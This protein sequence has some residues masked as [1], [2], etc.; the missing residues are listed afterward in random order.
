ME[1]FDAEHSRGSN[2]GDLQQSHLGREDSSSA[3]DERRPRTHIPVLPL[4][5]LS[6]QHAKSNTRF[7]NYGGIIDAVRRIYREE[8]F[9]AFFRGLS[10]SYL[11]LLETAIQ[12]TWYTFLS[13]LTLQ[14]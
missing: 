8:G 10:V 3:P 11:G 12:F 13:I 6:S 1:C 2:G 4:S 7:K 5:W 9:K 14:L